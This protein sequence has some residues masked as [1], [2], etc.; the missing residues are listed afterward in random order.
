MENVGGNS[1]INNF[2][3]NLNPNSYEYNLSAFVTI[4]NQIIPETV[5]TLTAKNYE[6]VELLIKQSGSKEAAI[7]AV[8]TRI[9]QAIDE[10]NDKDL[11]N[12]F[13]ILK[14]INSTLAGSL[15]NTN[16]SNIKEFVNKCGSKREARLFVINCIE[17]IV[18][19]QIG[20]NNS[21]PGAQKK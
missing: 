8:T 5:G 16:I 6:N 9:K 17:G 11:S 20:K 10:N 15:T 2:L 4:L 19:Q 18:K 7:L 13:S 14:V 3:N 1:N 21:A 12:T